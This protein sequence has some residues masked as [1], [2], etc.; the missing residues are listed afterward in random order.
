MRSIVRL[1][2][3]PLF[4]VGLAV[5]FRADAQAHPPDPD[6]PPT[7]T[8]CAS[9]CVLSPF[10]AYWLGCRCGGEGWGLMKCRECASQTSSTCSEFYGEGADSCY[11]E[12]GKCYGWGSCHY[13]G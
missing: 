12:N 5:S 2:T 6:V 8:D 9:E 1:S 13:T 10:N 4:V 3:T 11:F 7:S